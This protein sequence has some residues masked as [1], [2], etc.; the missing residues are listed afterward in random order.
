MVILNEVKTKK[1][2]AADAHRNV[3]FLQFSEST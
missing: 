2:H 1:I 3:F